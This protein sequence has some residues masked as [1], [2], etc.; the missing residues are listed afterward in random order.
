[1]DLY[2][3]TI[4]LLPYGRTPVDLLPCDGRIMPIQQNVLLF[5]LIR[6]TYGGN[7]STSFGLPNMQGLEPM[8]GMQYYIVARGYVPDNV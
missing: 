2:I 5:A 6:T 4:L 3:G 8:P 1:M 7:G